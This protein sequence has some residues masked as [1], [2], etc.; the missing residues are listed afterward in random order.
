M[1]AKMMTFP[2]DLV[3][4]FLSLCAV[5]ASAT[6]VAAQGTPL[7][8]PME[9]RIL[10][11]GEDPPVLPPAPPGVGTKWY[12][13][14][15]VFVGDRT[16][17]P[18]IVQEVMPLPIVRGIQTRYYWDDL[19]VSR[20][21]Y[22]FSKIRQDA[23]LLQERGK[24]LVIQLQFKTFANMGPRIPSYLTAVEFEGGSY[25]DNKGGWNL[26]LWNANVRS[27][28]AA[29]V[30]AMGVELDTHPGIALM[31][32]PESVAATPPA[33]DPLLVNWKYYANEYARQLASF[34]GVL[35][36]SF[37]T[38]PTVLYFNGGTPQVPFFEDASLTSG[39]GIGGPDTWIG[40][41]EHELF[42][43]YSY[44]LAKRL[45]RQVPVAYGIQ[46]E[47]YVAV[48]SSAEWLHTDG[49][50]PV[51]DLNKFSRDILGSNF[52]F[53]EKREPYWQNVKALWSKIGLSQGASGGFRAECP[54]LVKPCAP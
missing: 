29:L 44:D 49:A 52:A 22:D 8:E 36:K 43:R 50:V 10:G 21:K 54:E 16:N 34:G 51:T 20:G 12:P 18:S 13:G 23:E 47:N 1:K 40:A 32:F 46:W 3:F 15:Y 41:Y 2:C 17:I 48:G 26:R 38:T 4:L 11:P 7:S 5:F 35:R 14:H 28:L 53:W 37:P 33:G 30:E 24:K 42:V 45:A 39:V 9:L 25:Q 27:R 19:E 6:D 31:N